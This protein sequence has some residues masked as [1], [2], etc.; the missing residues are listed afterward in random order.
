MP[1]QEN[2]SNNIKKKL[3]IHAGFHKTGTTSIQKYLWVYRE[4]LANNNFYVPESC[5]TIADECGHHAIPMELINDPRCGEDYGK[6]ND[7]IEE[8]SKR[9]ESN[10]I[11]SSEDF[12]SV[13]INRGIFHQF[14]DKIKDLFEE[15]HWVIYLR[16]P[17]QWLESL[18]GELIWHGEIDCGFS[19]FIRN[20]NLEYL[21][22]LIPW[23][24]I[25]N[26]KKLEGKFTV[27]LFDEAK[28]GNLC[29]DFLK[30]IGYQSELPDWE[31]LNNERR[32]RLQIEFYR[33]LLKLRKH[34]FISF[35]Y[36]EELNCWNFFPEQIGALRT[37]YALS[38]NINIKLYEEYR[39]VF[40]SAGIEHSLEE[41]LTPKSSSKKSSKKYLTRGHISS[42]HR[43][44]ITILKSKKKNILE[45]QD[46]TRDLLPSLLNNTVPQQGC[47]IG[48][49]HHKKDPS[50]E[51]LPDSIKQ[52]VNH[53]KLIHHLHVYPF[54]EGLVFTSPQHGI[55]DRD[56][57]SVHLGGFI[58][59]NKKQI[60]KPQLL[61]KGKSSSIEIDVI[62]NSDSEKSE[63]LSYQ[64]AAEI[65]AADLLEGVAIYIKV[66][67][68]VE[69]VTDIKMTNRTS[70]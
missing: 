53:I 11:L 63:L 42:L 2:T 27:R 28:K 8:I 49:Y 26:I 59:V 70:L 61:V 3:F 19:N 35:S 69:Y 29:H 55:E 65:P 10:Y 13:L 32:S 43:A 56:L 34:G 36:L 1:E 33:R 44:I 18:Y 30:T 40:E 52:K 24:I 47:F 5:R 17:T 25:S 51:F 48:F 58:S 20:P 15:V 22:A 64:F 39:M 37:D 66:K 7:L 45:L 62:L 9:Q 54:L 14:K 16:N 57:K 12:C 23:T 38:E 60:N 46:K 4:R 21:P 31:Q 6:I 50:D 41:F 68:Y 67:Q